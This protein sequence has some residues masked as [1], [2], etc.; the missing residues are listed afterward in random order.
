MGDWVYVC[1]L[2]NVCDCQSYH[3]RTV[4]FWMPPVHSRVSSTEFCL[5]ARPQRC[6]GL[7]GWMY[8]L[9]N[10]GRSLYSQTSHMHHLTLVSLAPAQGTSY[11]KETTFEDCLWESN[12]GIDSIEVRVCGLFILRCP[13]VTVLNVAKHTSSRPLHILCRH[14]IISAVLSFTYDYTCTW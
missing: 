13:P 8:P 4:L 12:Y 9:S 2:W 6:A 10:T 11:V 1:F 7:A 14:G 3:I 5:H